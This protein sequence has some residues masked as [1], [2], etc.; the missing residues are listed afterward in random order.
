MFKIKPIPKKRTKNNNIDIIKTG[1]AICIKSAPPLT[2]LPV[3]P[4]IYVKGQ[5][6]PNLSVLNVF[7]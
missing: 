2:H 1:K 7:F 5:Y 4:I 6:T 3:H